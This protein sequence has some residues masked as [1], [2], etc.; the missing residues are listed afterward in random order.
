MKTIVIENID[1]SIIT[2]IV[3]KEPPSVFLYLS[4]KKGKSEDTIPQTLKIEVNDSSINTFLKTLND[5]QV[6]V[7]RL[8]NIQ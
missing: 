3:S 1:Y 4:S 2:P 8:L 5:I 6:E 7:D